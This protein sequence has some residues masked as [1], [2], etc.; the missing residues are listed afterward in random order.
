VGEGITI[1][2]RWSL[3]DEKS[4]ETFSAC[5]VF[6]RLIGS[7]SESTEAFADCGQK[8]AEGKYDATAFVPCG[9]ISSRV[10][11]SAQTRPSALCQLC[12][13]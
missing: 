7:T 4:G 2:A 13:S 12:S 11:K 1:D 3:A 6:I 10:S 5:A 8:A 9:G